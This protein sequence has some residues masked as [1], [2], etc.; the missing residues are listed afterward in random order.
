M[1]CGMWTCSET[2][3]LN[4]T[5]I[6]RDCSTRTMIRRGAAMLIAVHLGI[7]LVLAVSAL[8]DLETG[9]LWPSLAGL[10]WGQA[11]LVLAVNGWLAV[12]LLLLAS[13]VVALWILL[14]SASDAQRRRRGNRLL[15]AVLLFAG[16]HATLVIGAMGTGIIKGTDTTYVFEG[17]S[18]APLL[19]M[20]AIQTLPAVLTW[21]VTRFRT[22]P[23]HCARC[24]YDLVG[25]TQ[26]C[27]E[28][29]ERIAETGASS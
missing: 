15:T 16:T 4:Q 10:T 21:I 11:V 22:R 6:E 2:V 3:M 14:S 24:G 17:W 26:R 19:I 29:G 20:V 9:G 13:D 25:I 18:I 28:C 5:A 12:V 7:G 23:D 27:P 8:I 1:G